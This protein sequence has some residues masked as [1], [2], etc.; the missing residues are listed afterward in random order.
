MINIM[1]KEHNTI[2]RILGN[3]TVHEGIYYTIY[4]S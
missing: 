4:F 3:I 2:V 1:S